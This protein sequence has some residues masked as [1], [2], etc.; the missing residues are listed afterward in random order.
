MNKRDHREFT[1]T[2]LCVFSLFKITYII[3]K[4][5]EMFGL[6]MDKSVY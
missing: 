2:F 3:V 4:S 1:L 6:G 5:E